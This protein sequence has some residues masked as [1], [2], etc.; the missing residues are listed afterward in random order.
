MDIIWYGQAC[1]K[2]KGK[3]ASVVIDPF[4]PDFIGLK[5]PKDLEADLCLVTHS[6][7]D[8]NNVSL[9]V[10]NPI[11]IQGPGEYEAKGVAVTG[12]GVYHD[13]SQGSERGKN[14]IY[15]IEIDGLN[16]V[17]CGDLG[18]VLTEAQVQEVGSCDIL[19]VPVGSLFTVDGKQAAEVVAQLEPRIVIPMHYALA[20]LSVNLD[21]V[22]KFLKEMGAENI[23]PTNKLSIT[24]DKLP[25]E[26]QVV[27][28]SK[29]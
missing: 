17:H 24:K 13:Q 5:A 15:N 12:V 14:T 26:P 2:L 4:E 1:F 28:L 9:V 20:G 19:L 10:G 25:E 16:I 21:G 11:Q 7:G 23:Q 18:H 27:L 3:N 6:H 29:S 22:E 8:H